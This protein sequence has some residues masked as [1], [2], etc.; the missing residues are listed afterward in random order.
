MFALIMNTFHKPFLGS[1]LPFIRT[2][3]DRN[4]LHQIEFGLVGDLSRTEIVH[5]RRMNWLDIIVV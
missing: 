3:T 4:P 2:G 5:D 1:F